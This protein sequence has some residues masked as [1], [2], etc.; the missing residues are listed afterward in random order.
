[1]KFKN[2]LLFLLTSILLSG[3]HCKKD[4]TPEEQLPL[5]TQTGA[6][7]FGCLVNGKL[8]L[9]KG[10]PFGGPILSCAYQF[11]NGG[12]YFHLAAKN[13]GVILTSVAINTDSLFISANSTYVLEDF[14]KKGAASG[15]YFVANNNTT[16]WTEFLTTPTITGQ[17]KI[18]KFDEINRIVSGTFWFDAVNSIGEKVQV[19]NGRF[20]MKYSL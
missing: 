11:I 10:S 16:T 17:L 15:Q 2:L 1:M 7:T 20:D 12:Y 4:K 3:F 13:D 9:P 14:F 5:E 8:F 6:G 19:R 18:T